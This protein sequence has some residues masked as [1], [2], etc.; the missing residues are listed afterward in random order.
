MN[1]KIVFNCEINDLKIN[2]KNLLG[3][4]DPDS[5]ELVLRYFLEKNYKINLLITEKKHKKKIFR[6]EV[7]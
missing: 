4:A 5:T 7:K 2:S 3:V 1:K 6:V